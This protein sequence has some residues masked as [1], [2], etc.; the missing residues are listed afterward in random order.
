MKAIILA[1]GYGNRMKPLTNHIHKTLL[2]VNG[3]TIISRIITG[4]IDN[5]ITDVVVV[6]GYRAEELESYLL[7]NFHDVHLTFVRNE[8]YRETNNIFSMA[9]AFEQI[10]IDEDIVFIES[11]LIYDPEVISR[12]INTK[13]KNAALVCKYRSG[14]DGTVV[15]VSNNRITNVIPP[16]LQSN[17]FDFS[18]KY[19]TLNIYK[20]DQYFCEHEFK[21]LLV[22]YAKVIDDNCYYELI[23]GMLIYM[24]RE[25]INAV[26]I[27]DEKWAEVDDPNDL[28]VAEFIF[29]K[30][31]QFELL[32]ASFGGYWNYD[33]LDFSFIRNMYFPTGS[34][35]SEIRNNL[36]AL[37]HNYGST[38]NILNEKLSYVLEC[39]QNC[40][41]ALNGAS[42]I[43]PILQEYFKDKKVLIPNPTFGEYSRIFSN[44][45]TYSDQVGIDLSSV[46]RLIVQVDV[47]VFVNPNNP[48]GSI[49]PSE[50]LLALIINYPEK[51]FIVDESFIEFSEE[52]SL[53]E[54]LEKESVDNV[55]IL[56]SMSKSYGCPGVR[57]GAVYTSDS[58]LYNYMLA[59]IPIWNL[60]SI[61]EF[62][63]EIILKNKNS[64]KQSFINTQRDRE[65]F[66]TALRQ[67]NFVEEVFES[68]GNYLLI[69]LHERIKKSKGISGDLLRQDSIF[70]KAISNKFNDRSAYFRLAVR[71]PEENLLLIE[72]LKQ[73]VHQNYKF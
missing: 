5:C 50:T 32:E 24:Q 11:D 27:T 66:S 54:S 58:E 45:F 19:K 1:A 13:Y 17:N 18:D 39:S 28:R 63:L 21:K 34:M 68:H 33:I 55:L 3:E 6:T 69:K 57:L 64:L 44:C 41:I 16:H 26:I 52:N 20:F 29:G 70:I 7:N 8:R 72:K 51:Y 56:K 22:Y 42:Q 4:L 2:S 25:T 30:D 67:L 15:D 31:K 12:I 46:E 23:I 49:L 36:P 37:I 9:L 48:S 60:N 10:T 47:I 43:Y 14:L 73:S 35:I 65:I 61:A 62:T 53:I 71:L 40:L 38:Q 59:R